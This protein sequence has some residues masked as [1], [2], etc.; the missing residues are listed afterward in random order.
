[1]KNKQ[2][3]NKDEK[4]KEMEKLSEGIDLLTDG[5]LI[6]IL[7]LFAGLVV[8]FLTIAWIIKSFLLSLLLY[9]GIK[10]WSKI[11]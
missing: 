10:I 4:E 5:Q 6:L 7:V 2:T 3:L 9:G 8:P 11:K 1:M